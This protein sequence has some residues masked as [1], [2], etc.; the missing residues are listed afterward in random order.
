[1]A[2][3]RIRRQNLD[4][5]DVLGGKKSRVITDDSGAVRTKRQNTSK[6]KPAGKAAASKSAAKAAGRKSRPAKP[7]TGRDVKPRSTAAKA[8]KSGA[9]ARATITKSAKRTLKLESQG[10]ANLLEAVSGRM[11]GPFARA[12]EIL[13]SA[14]GRVIV[15]GMGKSGHVGHKMAATFS[16]T[17]TT[18]FFVHPSEASHGDL[19]MISSDDVILAMSWSGETV[20]LGSILTYS[21]RFA[22]PL[23]AITSRPDSALG[24]AADVVLQLPK[25]SEACPH[26]L[27][28]TTSTTMTLALGDCLAIALLEAKG[29]TAEDFKRIHPGGSLGAQLQYAEDVMHG[30][31]NLPLAGKDTPMSEAIVTMTQCA[32]GCLGVVDGRGRLI[33]VITDGDL[34]RHMGDDL[35]NATTSDIMTRKPKTIERDLLAS[36]ALEQLNASRITALFVVEKSKPIGIVHVHDLLRAGIA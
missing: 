35:L 28:P 21:R 27:A 10:L 20:E 25:A 12:V 3:K 36:A 13:H 32:F 2:A 22:V 19:G 6:S 5:M 26:G 33:G 23:I 30:A 17:G 4:S 31:E 7:D 34:R 18:A 14:T 1:M 29:F 16:S 9:L 11:A 24:K 15:T 8:R